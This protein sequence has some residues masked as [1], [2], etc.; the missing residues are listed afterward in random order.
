MFSIFV[1]LGR[2][3]QQG[4][5]GHEI[6][7]SVNT[8][9][10]HPSYNSNTYNDDIALLRLSSSVNFT[11]Y[12]RP[13]CLAAENSDFPSGT[14]SWITGWGQTASGGNTYTITQIY[15]NITK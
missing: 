12:I 9:L 1:Y 7:R 3:T 14:S 6:S 5:H 15:A 10:I 11:N 2:R 13:V 4:D 8:L